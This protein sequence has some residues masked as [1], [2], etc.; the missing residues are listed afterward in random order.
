[1]ETI[2]ISIIDFL[3]FNRNFDLFESISVIKLLKQIFELNF[4]T[5]T[6]FHIKCQFINSLFKT[7]R[8]FFSILQ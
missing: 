3:E 5:I 1:M 7:N 4:D 8:N 6:I 2:F